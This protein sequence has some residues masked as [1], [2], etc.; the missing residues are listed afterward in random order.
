MRNFGNYNL[1]LDDERFPPELL[2]HDRDWVIVRTSEAAMQTVRE[3]GIPNFISFDHDLGGEDTAMKFLHDL[4]AYS[5]D[6]NTEFPKDYYVHSQ[7][8]IGR[9]NITSLMNS[10]LKVKYGNAE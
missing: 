4:I 3:L 9:D 8:P 5:I 1:F 2:K 6:N 10:Y 7:N